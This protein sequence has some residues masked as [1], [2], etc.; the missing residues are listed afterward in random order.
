MS[1]E[2]YDISDYL[3]ES[4][5]NKIEAALDELNWEYREVIS[6]LID[7]Y[8][9][10]NG[11]KK[12]IDEFLLNEALIKLTK[13]AGLEGKMKFLEKQSEKII[14]ELSLNC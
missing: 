7:V 10:I 2:A 3:N 13:L 11:F 12:P 5:H 9:A 1:S 14:K 8:S 4:H 6:D